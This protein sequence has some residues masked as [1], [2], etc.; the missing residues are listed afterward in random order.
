MRT[1]VLATVAALFLPLVAAASLDELVLEDGFEGESCP[2]PEAA[3]VCNGVDDD[4]DHLVDADD[5]ELVLNTCAIQQGVC[6]G[7]LAP[8]VRCN[9]GSWQQCTAADYLNHSAAYEP[10]ET[11]CDGLDNDCNGVSDPGCP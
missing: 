3:E 8:A 5:P 6:S 9:G 4:C 11:S 7:S 1:K 10:V 2:T